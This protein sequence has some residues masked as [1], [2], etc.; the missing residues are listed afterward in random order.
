M[1]KRILTFLCV[2]GVG[3]SVLTG[4]GQKETDQVQEQETEQEKAVEENTAETLKDHTLMIYCGAGMQKPFQEIAEDFQNQTGCSMNVTYA[5]AGQI[6]SQITT[7]EEGDMFV[8]GSAD[9][10]KPVMDYVTAQ[11]DLVKHIPV[12]TVAEGN[13]KNITGLESLTGEDISIVMGDVEATPIG[14]IAKKALNEAGIYDMVNVIATTSTAPQMAM[15]IANGEAD[16]AVLWKENSDVEGVEIVD[17][18]DL[19]PYIKT[20]PAASLSCS[21]DDEALEAFN[22]YLDSGAAKEIWMKYGYEIAE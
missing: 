15:V 1:K 3:M 6:Q 18:D 17:T 4:C 21:A 9:E 7:A 16:A 10:L 2:L 12:L 19:A 8:A 11:K 20:I 13:P 5:N 22:E 14:K